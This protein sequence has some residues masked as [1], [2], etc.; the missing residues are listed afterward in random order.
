MPE[1]RT[2][3]NRP[4]GSRQCA[5]GKA[6]MRIHHGGMVADRSY[7]APKRLAPNDMRELA[8]KHLDRFATSK[9]RLREI[10]K[11]RAVR[12]T[13]HHGGDPT[14]FFDAIENT[15]D[16]LERKGLL[17]DQGYAGAKARALIGRGHSKQRIMANL[18]A[19][20]IDPDTARSALDELADEFG[21]AELAAARAYAKRRRLGPYRR[22]AAEP[23]ELRERDMAAMARAGF[24]LEVA[25][26]ALSEKA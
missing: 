17:S 2:I 5:L 11:R 24:S 15:L 8:L 7:R 3:F 26:K 22:N 12:S 4:N 18:L 14:A 25:R 19:K 1:I 10:L 9:R 21:D 6:L 23:T 16:W 13:Q 20:G